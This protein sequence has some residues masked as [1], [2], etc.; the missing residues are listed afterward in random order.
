MLAKQNNKLSQKKNNQKEAYKASIHAMSLA[1]LNSTS[2]PVNSRSAEACSD[3]QEATARI[4]ELE[5]EL[6]DAHD[7]IQA[8]KTQIL[9]LQAEL[10]KQRG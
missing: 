8:K 9:R 7:A 3:C 1:I 10:G 4:S 2:T 5:Q 6:A